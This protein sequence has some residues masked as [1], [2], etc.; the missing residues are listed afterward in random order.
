MNDIHQEHHFEA[1]LCLSM[2]RNGWRYS[3]ND[4]G[5]DR[6]HF[7]YTADLCE[8]LQMAWPIQWEVLLKKHGGAKEAANA[9]AAQVRKN[10]NHQ[11]TLHWL[12]HQVEMQ[13]LRTGF[14]LAEFRPSVSLNAEVCRRYNSNILRVVRQVHHSINNAH[15]SLDL[16]FFLNGIPVATVELKS[17]MTQTVQDAIQQYKTDRHPFPKGGKEEPLLAFGRG[18]LVHFAVSQDEAYMT[19]RLEGRNTC[20]LPFNRGN[21]GAAGNIPVSDNFPTCY[22]WEDVWE[23]SQWLDL[24]GKYLVAE[25]ER[26]KLKKMIFPRFHQLDATR[27]IQEDIKANGPGGKYLIQHSAGSGKTKSIAWTAHLLSNLH[28]NDRKVFK[29][30]IVISDRTV[31]DE[32]LRKDIEA[33]TRTSGVVASITGEH[34]SKSRQLGTALEENRQ[35]IVCT[36][37]TFPFL[38][39]EAHKLMKE[40]HDWQ[41]AIIADEAHS[42]MAGDTNAA[43]KQLL[44]P[45][46]AADLDD[47]GEVDVETML[48][49]DMTARHADGRITYVA[50]TATPKAKTLELFGVRDDQN[51]PHPF[52]VYTMRQAIEEGFILDV[53]QNYTTITMAWKLGHADGSDIDPDNPEDPF[54]RRFVDRKQAAAKLIGL[55]KLHPYNIAQKVD[56]VIRHYMK[57]VRHSMENGEDAKAMVVL[58]SRREAIRWQ[59]ALQAYIRSHHLDIDSLVAFSGSLPDE[60]SFPGTGDLSEKSSLLNPRLKGRNI[61]KAFIGTGECSNEFQ[62]LLVANKFQ[63][64]FDEPRLCGMYVNRKLGGVQTVQTLSRLNRCHP[65]KDHVYV[66]DFVNREEDI[67]GAFTPYY[68]TACI[69]E[70]TDPDI[71]YEL[72]QSIDNMELYTQ[73]TMEQTV[74]AIKTGATQREVYAILKP[75]QKAIC[76]RYRSAS[77][78]RRQAAAIGDMETMRKCEEEQQFLKNAKNAMGRYIRAYV[79]LSQITN[80]ESTTLE[81]HYLFYKMLVRLLKF[82]VERVDVDLSDVQLTHYA[83]KKEKTAALYLEAKGD[84]GTALLNEDA[85]PYAKEKEALALMIRRL[86]ELYGEGLTDNDRLPFLLFVS[87]NLLQDDKLIRQAASNTFE[88]FMQSPDLN[89]AFQNALFASQEKFTRFAMEAIQQEDKLAELKLMLLEQGQLYIE[90]RNRGLVKNRKELLND[91]LTE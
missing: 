81:K 73:E 45:E 59:K 49:A 38:M 54:M 79:F 11:G 34:S 75:V 63:T 25:K 80:Y 61:R 76:E 74:K 68:E 46:E 86:N 35:I 41:F 1:E 69:G 7:L 15:S 82:D 85:T 39:E 77:E 33:F 64:G 5:F 43:L 87:N 20:F 48:E 42:S 55:V 32:Q 71:I 72:Y 40:H 4:A 89:K 27:R 50:F 44:T 14:T 62:I 8:W 51:V 23:P 37:Q 47:G 3:D 16:V 84:V 52:H 90:L 56:I 60:E 29:S 57:T 18:A 88:Q 65:G 78:K 31:L 28:R 19:T 22:L 9:A 91:R 13:G 26:G 70:V 66:V 6:E 10:L 2:Q 21:H 36:L 17:E 67:L 12:R 83:K 58:G 24:L 53:L 30:I